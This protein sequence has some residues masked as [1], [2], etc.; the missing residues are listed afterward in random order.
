[1]NP[2]R[3]HK[4]T[5]F[6]MRCESV[7]LMA[8]ATDEHKLT[9]I[10][11]RELEGRAPSRLHT[12]FEKWDDTEVVP[13]LCLRLDGDYGFDRARNETILV[14]G[15]MHFVELLRARFLFARKGD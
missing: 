7:A 5:I 4:L 11:R 15:V 13:P 2:R 9:Q 1:M 10:Q 12:A 3:L 14:G 8:F 6:S